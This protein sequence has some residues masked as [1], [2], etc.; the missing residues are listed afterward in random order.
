MKVELETP[1]F[2]LMA[3]AQTVMFEIYLCV[4]YCTANWKYR[5]SHVVPKSKLYLAEFCQRFGRTT[6]Q[7]LATLNHKSAVGLSW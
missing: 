4:C 3:Q 1:V 5:V 7:N 2:M 6:K